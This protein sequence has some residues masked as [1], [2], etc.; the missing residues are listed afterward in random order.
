MKNSSNDL[1][2]EAK[3]MTMIEAP[4]TERSRTALRRAHESRGQALRDVWHW[5]F[6]SADAR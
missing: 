5:L 2:I 6:H 4:T 1:E 3:E